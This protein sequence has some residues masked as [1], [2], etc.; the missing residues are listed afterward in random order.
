MARV[1]VV[2]DDL[3]ALK[4]TTF[5]VG[6]AGHEVVS[7]ST[8]QEGL[9]KAFADPPDLAILDVMMPG[10]NGYEVCR[11][12][13]QN[14]R[15][16]H[17][18]ILIFTA[19]TQNVDRQ[20]SFQAGATEFLAKP[21]MPE[22]LQNTI[23]TLLKEASQEELS[24]EGAQTTAGQKI[25]VFSL[26]GGV[27]VTSLAANL[28]VALALQKRVE[29]LLADLSVWSGQTTL[30]LNLKP[31]LTLAEL[32]KA[33]EVL[34]MELLERY[35]LR[36]PSGVRVLPAPT[37]PAK[38][39]GLPIDI[40]VKAL[41]ILK[42]NF[43]YVVI[44]TAPALDELTLAALDSADLI[45]L[46][47][48]PDVGSV[49][50]ARSSLRTLASLGYDAQRVV[51]VINRTCASEGVPKGLVEK[52]LARPVETVIPYEPNSVETMAQ[53]KPLV[54]SHPRSA[55]TAAIARLTALVEKKL[56]NG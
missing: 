18:P 53:G 22:E 43:P 23:D 37:S 52:A 32:P 20:T 55:A 21:V 7:A 3:N 35:L 39:M 15:T 45:L 25:V 19:R 56:D 54:L 2:D 27:G 13:R 47:L 30:L 41:S 9:D 38:A 11:R 40:I 12:L 17:I 31:R 8:G 10:M 36:H 26:Q 50:T 29:V 28:A 34:D 24:A 6:K 16:A 46:V 14:E 4:F 5:V 49:Q 44:D 42:D 51:L 33:E 48:R 1:L